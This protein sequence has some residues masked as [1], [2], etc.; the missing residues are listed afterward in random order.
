ME[1]QKF[2][3]K[4][5]TVEGVKVTEENLDEVA[6]WCLGEIQTNPK[7]GRRHIRVDA[8]RP[9]TERQTMAMPGDWVLFHNRGYKVYTEAAF[10]RNFELVEVASHADHAEF[11]P[12][13]AFDPGVEQDTPLFSIDLIREIDRNARG[14]GFEVG[15]GE[16]Q[17]DVITPS[18]DNPFVSSAVMDLKDTLARFNQ[19]LRKG[20]VFSDVN[21]PI[22]G[23]PAFF[24]VSYDEQRQSRD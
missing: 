10:S 6:A 16:A 7:T 19:S 15:R 20:D 18:P 8:H 11:V 9:L 5:F 21:A 12:V 13:V 2:Q 14:Y 4:P 24:P 23:S 22:F 1:I 3:R 17:G